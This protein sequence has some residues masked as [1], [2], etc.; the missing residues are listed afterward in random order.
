VDAWD[1]PIWYVSQAG[2]HHPT[3]L[4]G[5]KGW[6]DKPIL[7]ERDGTQRQFTFTTPEA[8]TDTSTADATP[9]EFDLLDS[10][11]LMERGDYTGAVRRTVTAVEAVLRWALKNELSK[12]YDETEAERRTANTDNDFPGR[13]AQWRRLAQPTIAEVL[14]DEFARTRKLR[15]DIVHRALRLTLKD[16]A[17]AQRSVDT[18]RWLYNKIETKPEREHLR[19]FGGG[20]LVRAVGRTAMA[21]RFPSSVSGGGIV[22]TSPEPDWGEAEPSQ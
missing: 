11:S 22:L 21:P 12:Q 20:G 3:T 2:G 6:D 4:L 13:L 16:R 19:E 7:I 15:H 18:S 5:Y 9:G 17:L 14:F 8:I 10:R 1:V